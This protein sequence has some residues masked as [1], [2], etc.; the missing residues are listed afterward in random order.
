VPALATWLDRF[1]AAQ[2]HTDGRRIA[3]FLD[4]AGE[5]S[6]VGSARSCKTPLTT[7]G[8][9]TVRG[10]DARSF[11][12]GQMTTDLRPLSAGETVLAAWCSPKGR[13]IFLLRILATED[14]FHLLL[15]ADQTAPCTKRLRL[16]ALRAAVTIDDVSA[17]CGVLLLRNFP[18]DGL[19]G[20]GLIVAGTDAMRWCVGEVD[21]LARYWLTLD[22]SPRG[23]D[24]AALDFIRCGLPSLDA[25]LAETFLPQELDLDRHAAVSFE[26]GCYPGQEI[27]ARVRFR[28]SV[29]RRLARLSGKLGLPPSAG[30]RLIAAGTETAVGTVLDSVAL[31]SGQVELLAVL[32]VEAGEVYVHGQPGQAL[33]RQ[34]LP[35]LPER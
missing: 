29:K 23:E 21:A 11:L 7:L 26:K 30:H 6:V 19:T 9:I 8:V 32:D 34:A 4:R 12:H 28:G 14:G 15:P 25:S 5:L 10:A 3:H 18:V 27:V 24:A 22:G 1:A 17:A 13:V 2:P 16:Y 31:D 20:D 35:Q 33:E